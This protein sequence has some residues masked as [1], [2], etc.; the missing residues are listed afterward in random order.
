MIEWFFWLSFWVALGIGAWL[1]LLGVFARPP[2]GFSVALI[3]T[4]EG[5]LVIQLVISVTLVIGGASAATDTVEFFGYL[6]V[7]LLVPL[8]GFV[9]AIL[10]RTRWS[11]IVLAATALVVWVML[12]R[13][14]QLWT[15]VSPVAAQL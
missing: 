1:L 9:W 5:L 12:I 7:A 10:D 2:S 6:I 11:T 4:V 3:A 8:A 13:M 14:Q 15:G